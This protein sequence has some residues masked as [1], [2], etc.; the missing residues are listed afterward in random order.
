[1]KT[2]I[3]K[4]MRFVNFKGFRNATVKFNEG[5][6][7]VCGRNG[8][9]KTTLFDGFTW[10]LFGKDSQDRKTFSLKT[11]D[12][13]GQAIPRIPHEVSATLLVNGETV[14]LCRR[15]NEKWVKRAGQTEEAFT[16]H[17]EERLFNNVPL[18][19]KEWNDKISGI[20]PE[21]VFKFITNPRHFT[22]QKPEVQR[23]ML[24][25]MAGGLS[26]AEVAEGNEDFTALLASLTGKTMEEYKKE[27][28]AK[29]RRIKA[30]TEAI[31]G[32]IDERKRDIAYLS[33]YDY[34]AIEAELK[35]SQENASR[36]EAEMAD[37]SKQ[38]EATARARAEA[39]REIGR[40][41]EQRLE[42][43]YAVKEQVTAGYRE[44][45]AAK[46]EAQA[47]ISDLERDLQVL[48]RRKEHQAGIVE[49]CAAYREALIAEWKRINASALTFDEQDFVCPTCKRPFDIDD[50]ERRQQE[51]TENFNLSKSAR[52]KENNRKGQANNQ[53]MLE[54]KAAISDI[55]TGLKEAWDELEAV[56]S[57]EAYTAVLEEPDTRPAIESHAGY[58]ELTEEIA[59]KEKALEAADTTC[60]TDHSE[61]KM[62]LQAFRH[63]IDE[64]KKM[65]AN[66]DTIARNRQRIAELEAQYRQG[67][68]ELAGLERAELTITAFNKARTATIDKRINGLFQLVRFKMYEQQV[69]GGEVETCE[70]VVDGVPYSGQNKAMQVNMGIDIINAI[71]RS[72]GITAPIF[73]DNAESV[74]ELLPSPSQVI[75][76]TVTR[77][78]ELTI[79]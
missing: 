63:Q 27:I 24:F 21:Q 37:I 46:R 64:L 36:I 57:S 2:I 49:E 4:E 41:K 60:T 55:D 74:N 13:S 26:D 11:I 17:E 77:D 69:N 67:I 15:Y 44:A 78:N 34:P 18:S 73:I 70:A 50:I 58:M 42:L 68:Q 65:L 66:R 48:A 32:R 29:K 76:L 19:L 75:K 72:E 33:G 23:A 25:R 43:E 53:R 28:Q 9:G 56:Q 40:L 7:S 8:S 10:L 54:A 71:C 1:M 79:Q 61:R 5:V 45:L 31:P 22:S 38:S 20:C 30:E 16:G 35:K 39:V 3:I 47:R 51:M 59:R 6:T 14:E 62:D 52:L 12:G